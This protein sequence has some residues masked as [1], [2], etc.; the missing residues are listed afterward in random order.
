M[1]N[2]YDGAGYGEMQ[3]GFGERPAVVNVDFQLGFTDPQYPTGRS[4]HVHTAVENT[5]T[6]LRH[7]RAKG[8]PVASCNVGWCGPED[9]G[10][11]KVSSLY[12]GSFFTGHPSMHLDPRIYE[13]GYDVVF[14]KS[15][16]SIFF[17]TPLVLFLT[18][19]RVDTVIITGCTTSGCVRASINDCFSYGYRTI[20]P[21]ECVGDMEEGPHNDNLRDVGRRYADV[22]KLA[23][24]IAYLDGLEARPAPAPLAAVSGC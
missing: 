21:E 22:M 10:Y 24:V 4:A 19:Q 14:T 13:P 15:A 3:I 11:W 23:D 8:V 12:D 17:Q 2:L 20:V 18:K 16:P 1:S 6:L 7:A 5:A 9:M